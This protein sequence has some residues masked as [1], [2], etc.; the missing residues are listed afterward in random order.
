MPN[1]YPYNDSITD[2]PQS[3]T[4]FSLAN[5][6]KS[7]LT[8]FTPAVETNVFVKPKLLE[9]GIA[10]KKEFHKMSPGF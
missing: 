2:Y 7:S 1:I 4:T 6:R 3:E 10:S 9:T 5:S 8:T